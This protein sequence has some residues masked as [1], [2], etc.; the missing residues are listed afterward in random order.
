METDNVLSDQMQVRGP[1]LL[2]L[3]A[4]VSVRIVADAGN[5]VGKGV[6]PYINHMSVVKINRDAPFE[7]GPGYTQVLQARKEEIVHHLV[8]TGNGL[9]ELRMVVNMLNQPVRIF[10][11]FEEIGLFL[12]GLYFSAA[13]RALAVYQLGFGPEGLAG[14]TVKAFVMSFVN[15]PLIIQAFEN[16]LYLLYMILICGTDKFIIGGSH[17]IPQAL[18]LPCHAVHII[19]RRHTGFLG[20][21]LDLL[22]MLVRSCLEKYIVTVFSFKSGNAVRQHGLIGVSN[23]RFA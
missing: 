11:H 10:A 12:G 5:I 9:N 13:V 4:A 22:P 3:F 2:I 7:G 15:I 8:F 20:L 16:L 14:G 18:H 6:Q 23:V 17:E 19:L 21:Q 1:Q